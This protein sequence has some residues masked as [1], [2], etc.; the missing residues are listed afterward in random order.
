[1]QPTE[2]EYLKWRRDRLYRLR[3]GL[4]LMPAIMGIVSGLVL[5][6]FGFSI[7]LIALVASI[8]LGLSTI[9]LL[10]L[11]LQSG[12]RRQSIQD[13][14]Y[15]SYDNMLSHIN[16]RLA[17]FSEEESKKF[18]YLR[19]HLEDLG[20]A[21]KEMRASPGV[22][23]DR[24]RGEFLNLIKAKLAD[25]GADQVLAGMRAKIENR[26]T[27]DVRYQSIQK[28]FTESLERLHQEVAALSRRGN[29]NLVLGIVTTVTGLALLG[30]Y[31]FQT[32]PPTDDAW[33]FACHFLPRLTLV[34]F[35][36]VF[37][38]FFLSLYK[39]SLSEIKYF[40]NEMTNLEAKS[41]ALETSLT[42]LDKEACNKVVQ[43]LA[44]TERNRILLKGQTTIDIERSK[45]SQDVVSEFVVQVL[46][47]LRKKGG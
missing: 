15:M 3:L 42:V 38:Y 24:E 44:K 45:I 32:K 2:E 23:N 41:I 7:S 10:M 25:E 4:A 35:I 13:G 22:L 37:A 14:R 20:H 11:Y 12:F 31:V 18:D 26:L 19:L 8:S 17:A 27:Q 40:Q 47:I 33:L 1:M 29:L 21:L 30:Y 5:I 36:E 16:S 43:E 46:D 28:R 9:G 34:V 6:A 39:S